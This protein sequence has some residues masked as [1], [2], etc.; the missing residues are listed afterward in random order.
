[1]IL[2]IKFKKNLGYTPPDIFFERHDIKRDK[3]YTN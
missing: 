1:M 3:T 2:R